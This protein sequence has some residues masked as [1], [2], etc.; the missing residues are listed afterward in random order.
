MVGGRRLGVSGIASRL[1]CPMVAATWGL[2]ALLTLPA[3]AGEKG[4]SVEV[5]PVDVALQMLEVRSDAQRQRLE[6]ESVFVAFRFEDR[7]ETSGIRFLHQAVDDAGRSYKPVHYDH[8]NGL[9][10]ADVDGDG[11]LDV[12]FTN[13]IGPNELWLGSGNGTFER[14]ADDALSLV[15]RISVAASFGDVDNDGDPDLFVTT[16]RG[17]NVLFENLGEGKYRDV[18]DES[19]LAHS[20]HS[21]GAQFVDVDSD[22]HLDLLVTNVG[23]YT[24]DQRGRGGYHV[25]LDQAF[26]GH[27]HP[28]RTERSLLYRNLGNGRFEDVSSR[29]GLLDDGW[30]G[31]A[32]FADLD[33]D[34]YPELYLLNMQGDDR[35]YDNLGGKHFREAT[36]ATFP[37]TPWG[38]MG[39]KFFD[40]D[41]DTNLDLVL[42][43]MHSDMTIDVTPG[44][45]KLKVTWIDAADEVWQGAENNIFGNAFFRGTGD[46]RF[47]ELSDELGVETFWPWG[48]S[49][50]DLNADGWQDILVTA[51]MNFPFRYGLNSV[52]LNVSGSKFVD[53]EL[54][55]GVE[56]RRAV[57]VPWFD[58]DCDAPGPAHPLCRRGLNGKFTVMASS[59]SRGSAI[60]DLDGDGDLDILTGEFNASPQVLVSDLSDR[61]PVHFVE[62]KLV[63]TTSNRDGLGARLIVE[64]DGRRFVRHHDGKS[65]YLSQSSMPLHVAVGEAEVIDRIEVQW[66]SGRCQQVRD[67]ADGSRLTLVEPVVGDS[68][69]AGR[70]D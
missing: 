15:D 22:G 62:V 58:V 54:M 34:G 12:Y 70:S 52:L 33:A 64:A 2:S 5:P 41:N 47:E 65:G 26:D 1:R 63:G 20:G 38:T 40:F 57:R 25:G 69:G 13:Q 67:V 32:A 18:T 29:M 10:V 66:P 68:C 11:H 27:L 9:A 55:L 3:H 14:L 28:E 8:G 46:G 21:S 31:D 60:F 56:P 39:I 6:R 53:A 49:V 4:R 50:G 59:G 51:G 17:G 23:Q 19:G 42:T 43:D 35:Y 24:S 36:A 37:K 48:V 7:V 16:V 61:R 30:T 44:Y 45:E